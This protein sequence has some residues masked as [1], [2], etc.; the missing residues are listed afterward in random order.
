MKLD[1]E[2]AEALKE[3]GQYMIQSDLDS[4]EG[5]IAM[6]NEVNRIGE[7]FNAKLDRSGVVTESRVIP[8]PPDNPE[9][10][11]RIHRPEKPPPGPLPCLFHVHGGGMVA[12]SAVRDDGCSAWC[13]RWA[14]WPLRWSTA[15]RPSIARRHWPPIATGR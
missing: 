6:R 2:I 8:G 1:P 15:S 3:T 14:A 13:A 10:T 9:L 7:L 4:M 12:G 11:I 5:V